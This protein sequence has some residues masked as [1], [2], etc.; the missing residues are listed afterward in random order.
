[1]IDAPSLAVALTLNLKVFR[2]ISVTC[3]ASHVRAGFAGGV[4]GLPQTG[5]PQS[6]ITPVINEPLLSNHA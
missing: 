3:K 4:V 5:L 6:L 2:E 1:M